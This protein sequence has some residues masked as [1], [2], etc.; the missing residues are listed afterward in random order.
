MARDRNSSPRP[1]PALPDVRGSARTSISRKEDVERATNTENLAVGLG[2]V[3]DDLR[4]RQ[5]DMTRIRE[6]PRQTA[7]IDGWHAAHA[8]G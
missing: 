8:G 3:T 4:C 6:Q 7:L 1:E 2:R 5:G